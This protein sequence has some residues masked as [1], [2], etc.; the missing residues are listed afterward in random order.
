M[1]ENNELRAVVLAALMVFSVFGGTIAFAGAASAVTYDRGGNASQDYNTITSVGD[2]G[3]GEII[4]QGEEDI[5]LRDGSGNPLAAAAFE[6]ASGDNAGVPLSIPVDTDQTTG[7]YEN[8]S[9]G[10]IVTVTVASPSISTFDVQNQPLGTSAG[11]GAGSDVNGGTLVADGSGAHV[12]VNYNFEEAESVELTVEDENGVDVTNEILAGSADAVADGTDASGTDVTPVG[13]GLDPTGLDEGEY[14]FSISGTEDLD[15]GDATQSTTVQIVTEEAANLD[16]SSGE[17]VQGENVDFTIDGTSE[18]NF[19]A[20]A[21][22]SE[23]FRDGIDADQA[24]SIFRNVG[25]TVDV[26]LVDNSSSPA[27]S[28]VQSQSQR[29]NIQ[30]QVNNPNNDIDEVAELTDYAFAIVEIDGGSGVGSI[31]TQFLDDSSVTVDVFES[32]SSVTYLDTNQNHNTNIGLFSSAAESDDDEDIEIDEGTVSLS[33]PTGTYVTGNEVTVNGTANEGADDVAIYVRDQGDYE[34][35]QI[36]GS[37]TITVDGDNTFDEEDVQLGFGSTASSQQGN[38]ILSLPGTYRIGVIVAQ[39]AA[40]DSPGPDNSLTTSEFN[41]GISSTESVVVTDTELTGSFVTYNGQVADDDGTIDLNGTAAG[42]DGSEI[43]VAFVDSRG[44]TVADTV[45]VDSDSTF[46]REDFDISSLSQG[47]VSAHLI[48]SGRDGVF[49]EDASNNFDDADGTASFIDTG[50]SG[51]GDQVRSSILANTV[52]DTASDDLIVTET[53]R[54]S[55]GLTT[56]ETVT[57]PVEGNGTIEVTGQTNRRA[58]DNTITAELL[59]QGDNSVTLSS[60]DQWG[61]DGAYS[62]NISLDGVQPGEYVVEVDDGDNTDR[63]SVEVVEQVDEEETPTTATPEPDTPTPT[64]T[65]TPEPDTPTPTEEPADDTE[66][67]TPSTDAGTPG[68]GIVVALTALIAAALLA[69][70]RTN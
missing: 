70:R 37:P 21:I 47:T 45:S 55:D 25:D 3:D 40:I 50:L 68:F 4:F 46:E 66:T 17:V 33:E 48:S 5:Q 32:N 15:F 54:L 19:H 18:G 16:L 36:D 31:E 30:A 2:V 65:A 9:S 69:V 13:I 60:T 51:T 63:A 23:D 14:T 52:D 11:V 57:S 61:T 67:D 56:V 43:V 7:T 39:D 42:K 29:S 58:D 35:A 59:D 20:V 8:S 24:N 12:E 41:G 6:R 64:P 44:N 1:T 26:G 28:V 53:F 49:G 62:V 38:N 34:L 27:S 22:Q 10:T